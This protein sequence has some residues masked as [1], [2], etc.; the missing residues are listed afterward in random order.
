MSKRRKEQNER[1]KEQAEKNDRR[2][3]E[4]KKDLSDKTEGGFEIF[5]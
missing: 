1:E 3:K 2:W 4:R 5:R